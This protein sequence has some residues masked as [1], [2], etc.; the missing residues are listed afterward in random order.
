MKKIVAPLLLIITLLITANPVFGQAPVSVDRKLND[1]ATRFNSL[2]AT[3]G[4]FQIGGNVSL[5]ADSHLQNEQST[6]SPL[7][8]SQ[9]MNLFFNAGI[10]R[11]LNFSMKLSH[12]GGWGLNYLSSSSLPPLNTP[13]Q[14]DEA[15]L[16][17]EYPHTLNYLGRFRFTLGPLGLISD[18]YNNPAEGIALQRSFN[19]YHLVGLYS[20]I[21]TQMDPDSNQIAATEEYF[22]ARFGWS[23]QSTIVGLNIVP[24]GIAAEK[25]F[26]AD[27]STTLK[28][29]RIAAEVGW[30]AFDSPRY[31]D[32]RTGWTPGALV[33]YSQTLPKQQGYFEVK[34][35]YLSPNFTPSASVLNH[36]ADD[37]REWFV[38]NTYGL[39]FFLQ[40]NLARNF[41]LQN[42]LMG[43]RPVNDLTGIGTTYR[44]RTDLIKNLSQVNQLDF[45]YEVK[46]TSDKTE[47][48]IFACWNLQF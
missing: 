46:H 30:Y 37:A 12:E 16:K 8:Y 9:Q 43:S 14:L 41:S 13:L 20:R 26:S 18:F 28:T 7:G 10:D 39:E 38:T 25:A 15:F 19:D 40:N 29:G 27:Y 5:E 48:R 2:E 23:N 33:S 31:P 44:L 35:G 6:L 36:S 24:S 45:G 42:R 34:A 32:Y 3:W 11:N 17:M 4:R 47:S 21:N 22:A 1:L